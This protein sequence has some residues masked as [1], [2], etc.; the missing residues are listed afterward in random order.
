MITK[1]ISTV[2]TEENLIKRPFVFKGRRYDMFEKPNA[3][4]HTLEVFK[5]KARKVGVTLD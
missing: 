4:Q 5:K 2:Q 3:M 1:G